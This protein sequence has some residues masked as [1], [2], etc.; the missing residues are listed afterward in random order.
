MPK[1]KSRE[2]IEF[3]PVKIPSDLLSLVDKMLGTYSYRSRQ[4]FVRDAVRRLLSHYG[5]QEA[6]K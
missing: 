5:V 1:T 3:I 4:E 2:K 6:K